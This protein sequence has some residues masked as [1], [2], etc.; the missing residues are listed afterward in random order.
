MG[1][2]ETLVEHSNLKQGSEDAPSGQEFPRPITTKKL[3]PGL[4]AALIALVCIPYSEPIYHF[5]FHLLRRLPL[6][7]FYSTLV[8]FPTLTSVLIMLTGIFICQAKRRY[9]IVVFLVAMLVTSVVNIPIKLM[10]AR[11]RPRYSIIMGS[12]EK[13][14]VENYLAEH[15][16]AGMK[17]ERVDQWLGLSKQRP[18][19][20][21]GYSS[22]P[23][24]HARSSFVLAAYLSA[25]FPEARVVWYIA[26]GGCAAARVDK[27]RHWPEDV[28]F[29]G[30]VGWMVA[31]IVFSWHW[32][33]RLGLWLTRRRKKLYIWRN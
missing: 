6:S 11:A 26:A 21:D 8:Q 33:V 1:D 10:T 14:W 16:D 24:G 2:I 4:A 25:L 3:I 32:P 9:T 22:F 31:K 19:F 28:L 20:K 17:P 12:E 5:V 13:T 15:P 27:E 7:G 30:A 18:W 29:G 23:S